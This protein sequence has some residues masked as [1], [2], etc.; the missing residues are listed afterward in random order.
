VEVLSAGHQNKADIASNITR[1]WIDRDGVDAIVDVP[2]SS[3][4]LAVVGIAREKNKV[5]LASGPAAVDL[6]GAQCSQNTAHWT[7][8]T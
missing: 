8:D 4:A 1:Q 6:T 7:Y 3:A 5:F 2:G